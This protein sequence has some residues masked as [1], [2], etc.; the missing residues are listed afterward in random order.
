MTPLLQQAIRTAGELPEV[1]QDAL[2]A[3]ILEWIEDQRRW[4]ESFARTHEALAELARE[5]LAEHHAG[6]TLN[7]AE[8][9]D[10]TPGDA[11][12]AA[13]ERERATEE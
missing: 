12:A 1:E 13:D 4:A 5:A 11:A 10:A 3:A 8:W 7:A 2:A 6:H 9:L